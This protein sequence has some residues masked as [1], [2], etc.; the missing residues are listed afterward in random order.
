VTR[1]TAAFPLLNFGQ[2][3][4]D[5]V[6][7][8]IPGGSDYIIRSASVMAGHSIFG[9]LY[10]PRCGTLA[11]TVPAGK[12]VYITN[13]YYTFNG[14]SMASSHRDDFEGALEYLKMHYPAL[15]DKMERGASENVRFGR[16][17]C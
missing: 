11:F 9:R 13:L 16:G 3:D 2:T 1:F 5:Y 7:G 6:V 14:Y 8:K 12:V 4:G 10:R 15:A 17:Q